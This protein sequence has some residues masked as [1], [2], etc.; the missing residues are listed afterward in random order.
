MGNRLS[1]SK[2]QQILSVF[3]KADLSVLVWHFR[4]RPSVSAVSS[5]ALNVA[6]VHFLKQ[7]NVPFL[8]TDVLDGFAKCQIL[9]SAS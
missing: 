1:K 7:N 2:P 4:S 9:Q 6:C 5:Q 8:F 3:L